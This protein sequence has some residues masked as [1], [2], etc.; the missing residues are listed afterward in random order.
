MSRRPAPLRALRA[1]LKRT[2]WPL[3]PPALLLAAAGVVAQWSVAGPESFP[4]DH[5]VRLAAAGAAGAA[6]AALPPRRWRALAGRA[7]GA[8]LLLL[9]V[10]LLFGQATNNARRWLDLGGGFKVQPSE[11]MKLALVLV[12]ARWF[13]DRP[14]PQ[15]LRDLAWPAVLAAL[16][17]A[18]V[19]AEPDLGTALVYAPTFLALAWLA[20]TPPRTMRWLLVAPAL[21]APLVFLLLRDYQ[22]E[23][24]V[25]W[26][27]QDALSAEEKAAAGYHLWHSKLA[28]GGGGWLGHGFAQ[29]PENRLDRLP[30]RH[31][32][33]VFPVVAEEFGFAGGAALILAYFSLAALALSR[34]A[35]HR[36]LFTRLLIAGVG[37]HFAVHLTINVGVALGLWPTAGLPL[38]LVSW[39]GSSMLASAVAI[40]AA[41]SAG[42]TREPVLAGRDYED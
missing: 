40:G 23:R 14:R 41:L 16:P 34:A 17:A 13:A 11:F 4:A 21:L 24:V 37:V 26:W 32:D 38:P 28:V 36:D 6:A 39:G 35:R 9:C 3:I 29:G 33:F 5:A 42:A 22:R 30:E 31:T 12:L 18:L 20:G 2:E 10:V 8:C 19:L 7:Y 15:R 1:F 25:T 27:R